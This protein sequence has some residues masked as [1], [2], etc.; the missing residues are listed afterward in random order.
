MQILGKNWFF[1]LKEKFSK[2]SWRTFHI[3]RRYILFYIC[4]F[5]L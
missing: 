1:G 3:L 2:I 5:L 4:W